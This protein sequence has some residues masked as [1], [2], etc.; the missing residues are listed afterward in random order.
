MS[1]RRTAWPDWATSRSGRRTTTTRASV[2]PS[3][4]TLSDVFLT[5]HLHVSYTGHSAGRYSVGGRS[6]IV[7]E[8]GTATSVRQRGEVNAFNLLR[9]TAARIVVER[10]EWDAAARRFDI[11]DAQ[12]FDKT[13]DGW[14]PTGPP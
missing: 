11:G 12:Q 4:L 2:R 8:A 3:L 5:G 10:H 9:I 6:A 1:R 7:V 13:P 14:A